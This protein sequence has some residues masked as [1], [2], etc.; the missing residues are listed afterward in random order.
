MTRQAFSK[1]RRK[2]KWEAFEEALQATVK[3][4]YH[5]LCIWWRDWRV[6]GIDGSFI[7]LPASP[8]LQAYFGALGSEGT[9]ACGLGIDTV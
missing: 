5:E 7:R 6:V 2:I 1:A 8:A 4:S 9:S 3:G